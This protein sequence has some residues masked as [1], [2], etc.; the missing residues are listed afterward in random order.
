MKKILDVLIIFLLAF[1][2]INLFQDDK[3]EEVLTWWV[4][5]ISQKNAYTFPPSVQLTVKNQTTEPITFNTCND[6]SI[7]HSSWKI[8]M[9]WSKACADVELASGQNHLVDFSSEFARFKQAWDYNV[10]G[11]IAWKEPFSRFELE[12][13][14]AISKLFIGLV[15][16]P[17]LNL[18][19]WLIY[20]MNYSLWWAIIIITIIVRIVLLWPQHKMMLSQ[21]KLQA[22]QPKIKE[23]QDKYKWQQQK[24]WMELMALYKKEKVNPMGSCGFLL[25]QMPILF[26]LYKVI[27]EIR[28]PSNAYYLYSFIQNFE[29]DK[30]ISNFYWL[31]LF[32]SY[33]VQWVLLALF[34]WIIQFI[35]IKLSLGDKLKKTEKWAVLEKKK[36]ADSYASMMPDQDVM[37]KFMLYWMPVMVAGFTFTFFAWLGLYWWMSTLFMIFQ[38][39]FVNKIINKNQ[40]E[41]QEKKEAKKQAK[42]ESKNVRV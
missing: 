18:M 31:Q 23:I 28:D 9:A 42:K 6:I 41:K 38:Q 13:R 11:S 32:E 24:L 33:W 10:E 40:I 39:M 19:D 4:A 36:D 17:I 34:V 30:I 14:G 26:V 16:Q 8:D 25:I 20:V 3:K 37:N 27:M 35:Q 21:K 5:I 2:I 7:K 12:H 29:I 22:I 1:L 15:Y